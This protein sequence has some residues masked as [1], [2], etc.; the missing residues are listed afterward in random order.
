MKI[1]TGFISNSSSSSFIIAYKKERNV[2]SRCGRSDPNIIQ[3]LREMNSKY[4]DTELRIEG[5]KEV[6][7][8]IKENWSNETEKVI[9]KIENTKNMEIALIYISYHDTV[10][11]KLL[12]SCKDIK[13]LTKHT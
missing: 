11:R 3:I 6:I 1:R 9:K 4:E 8:Y 2:C 13:I 10:L 5:K 12:K 7:E